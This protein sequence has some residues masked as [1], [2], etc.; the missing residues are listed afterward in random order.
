MH[1]LLGLKKAFGNLNFAHWYELIG[2]IVLSECLG[3]SLTDATWI[4]A[5]QE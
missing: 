2:L 1:W 3:T 4:S 5:H